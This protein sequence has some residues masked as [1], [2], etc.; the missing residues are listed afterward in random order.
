MEWGAATN[1]LRER[2]SAFRF[3]F[4]CRSCIPRYG[5]CNGIEFDWGVGP[6][7]IDAYDASD[8][9]WRPLDYFDYA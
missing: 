3:H 1:Y 8:G 6:S 7:T 9:A 2:D 5:W 4:R